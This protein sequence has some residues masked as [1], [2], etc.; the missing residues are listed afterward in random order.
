LLDHVA[1]QEGRPSWGVRD[2]RG[3]PAPPAPRVVEVWLPSP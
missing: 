3:Y 1:G 2:F